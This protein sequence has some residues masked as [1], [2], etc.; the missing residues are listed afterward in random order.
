MSRFDTKPEDYDR[1]V[2][3]G[4]EAGASGSMFINKRLANDLDTVY[5]TFLEIPQFGTVT[6]EGK[7]N[8]KGQANVVSWGKDGSTLEDDVFILE[9]APKHVNR[10]LAK[11][12]KPQYGLAK[13]Y[14]IERHGVANYQQTYYE[15]EFVRDLTQEEADHLETVEMHK[16]FTRK[17]SDSD[18]TTSPS[19]PPQAQQQADDGAFMRQCGEQA[20]RLG[21]AKD[22]AV[23]KQNLGVANKTFFKGATPVAEMTRD[24]KAKF[25]EALLAME[26]GQQPGE[27]VDVSAGEVLDLDSEVD[28]F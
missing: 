27:I 26:P 20:V 2:E 14:E 22:K 24:T 3:Q 18:T 25:L 5:V 1:A 6:Y 23:L 8:A 28:F 11:L 13:V 12:R 9:M 10:F 21:W 7:S 15:M 16:L 4:E 17:D 19:P